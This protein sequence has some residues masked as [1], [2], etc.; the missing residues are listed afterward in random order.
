M[1]YY[2]GDDRNEVQVGVDEA[3][4]G[5]LAGPVFAAAVIWNPDIDASQIKDSKKLSKKKRNELRLYIEK[6]ATAFS[7]SSCD[8][9]IIDNI[10]ILQATF[11]AMHRCLKNVD[12]TF[13]RI[14]VDGDK[15]NPF[16]CYIHDCI[17]HGDDQYISIAAASI[18]AKTH[19]DEWIES[20]CI[21]YTDLNWKY[22]WSTNMAYGTKAHRDGILM[23]GI[24][25]FHRKTFCKKFSTRQVT[26]VEEQDD[27]V[28]SS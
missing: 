13:E 4:R 23:H 20:K 7:V 28:L 24:S 17:P 26:L 22:K 14:I 1:K 19:H 5:S 21:E 12:T 27:Q 9:E 6:N 18:L 10:N 11:C 15:F 8:H 25:Q 16:M 3:G 2:F